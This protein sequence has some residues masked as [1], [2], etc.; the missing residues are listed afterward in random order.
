[1]GHSPQQRSIDSFASTDSTFSTVGASLENLADAPLLLLTPLAL[2]TFV[3]KRSSQR[4]VSSTG[5]DGYSATAC[6]ALI[7]SDLS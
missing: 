6:S 5:V 4:V 3:T 2:S 1:M 7:A